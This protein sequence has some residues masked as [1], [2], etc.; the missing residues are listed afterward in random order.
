MIASIPCCLA[1]LPPHER[2]AFL[3]GDGR[4]TVILSAAKNLANCPPHEILRYARDDDFGPSECQEQLSGRRTMRR[5]T[6]AIPS[7]T[8]G[9][10]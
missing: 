2:A 10:H 1:V 9:H 6:S 5:L 4:R 3:A 7:A 8:M